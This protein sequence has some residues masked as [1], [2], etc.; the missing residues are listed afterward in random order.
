MSDFNGARV[1]VGNAGLNG[2]GLNSGEKADILSR[3][4]VLEGQVVPTVLS[5]L[6]DV[7]L[8]GAAEGDHLVIDGDGNVVAETPGG[9]TLVGSAAFVIDGGGVAITT[10]VKGDL[11][12]M[13]F[14]GTITGWA[15]VANQSGSITVNVW[16]DTLANFPPTSDD[17]LFSASLSSA[18]RSPT[19]GSYTTVSH[20]FSVG[21]VIRFNVASVTDI[22]RVTVGLRISR[23]VG[24]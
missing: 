19:S 16:K 2:T 18:T 20:A 5:D 21:D 9:I 7:D 12:P 8:S 11:P 3:I 6:T 14:A 23:T 10:G 22:Q 1:R 13:P 17:A 4:G 15:L 24:P